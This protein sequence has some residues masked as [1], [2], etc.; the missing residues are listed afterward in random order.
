[1]EREY[2]VLYYDL[3]NIDL[4]TLR[5]LAD[6][7]EEYFKRENVP[8]ILLPKQMNME[9][10]TKEEALKRI[11]SIKEYVETWPE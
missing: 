3:E 1:M 4:E 6:G 8:F 5:E 2:P 11:E 10:M 9:W 7:L